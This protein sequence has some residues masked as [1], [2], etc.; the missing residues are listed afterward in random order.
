MKQFVIYASKFNL[1]EQI[2][3]AAIKT[4]P[5]QLFYQTYDKMD[6]QLMSLVHTI[7]EPKDEKKTLQ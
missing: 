4:N 1:M 7:S 2:L 6:W 5:N 3:L